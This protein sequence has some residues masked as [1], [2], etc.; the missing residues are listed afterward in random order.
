VVP[1]PTT[2]QTRLTMLLERAAQALEL[3]RMVERDRL[4]LQH[5]AQGGL[6]ADLAA[7]RIA[8][9]GVA[10]ARATA[11]GLP[12]AAEYVAVVARPTQSP[13]EP[14]GSIDPLVEHDRSRQLVEQLT[15]AVSAAGL[16]GL[17]GG[18]VGDQVGLLLAV[19]STRKGADAADRAGSSLDA[20]AA[21][22]PSRG[23]VLGVGPVSPTVVGS[24][25]GLAQA[26]HV[27]EVAQA[28]PSSS[29]R[30]WYRHADVRLPGLLALLHADPRVQAF[31]ES[32]LGGLLEHDARRD[33]G[34]LD[35]LRQYVAAG[36]N[37]TRVAAA[38]HRSRAGVYKKLDRLERV[39]G[40]DL[41]DPT[42]LM[43]LGVALLAYDQG[44]GA[45]RPR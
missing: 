30:V 13:T 2:S 1:D 25:A 41:D 34:M 27:A 22:L 20:L 8:E 19:P 40:A 18:L 4:S 36:G 37:K 31:V 28:M 11:L 23:V 33:D 44:H 9:E 39:L 29:D 38:S 21:E 43:S 7:G 16:T 10:V 3:G 42:S 35:L 32:E 45:T 17:V 26:G 12:R 15:R 14:A 6:L 24:G 5:R